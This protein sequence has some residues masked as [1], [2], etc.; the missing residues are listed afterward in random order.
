MRHYH[1]VDQLIF[2]V[3]SAVH[4]IFASQVN[5]RPNPSAHFSDT[6]LSPDEHRRSQGFM[7]I[8]HSGEVCAQALYRGQLVFAKN[9]SNIALLQQAA[10]EETDHL[11]WTHQRLIELKTHRSYLNLFWYI[12]SFCIGALASYCGDAFSLGFV[13]ETE[14][15]VAAHL[16]DHLE[17]LAKNDIRSEK[18]ILQMRA[19]EEHHRDTASASGAAPLPSCIKYFMQLH[20][21]ILT[22]LAYYI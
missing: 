3:D 8:N 19:D 16:S 1:W 13:E 15:Q 18:I 14:R 6:T 7:R 10:I 20:A 22:T 12:N 21:K 2:T 4:T 9:E 17:R 11:A 5:S